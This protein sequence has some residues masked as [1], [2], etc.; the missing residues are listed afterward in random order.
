MEIFHVETGKVPKYSTESNRDE[1]LED[2]IQLKI[3]PEV[4]DLTKVD[5]SII[6]QFNNCFGGHFGR[7][8]GRG[9]KIIRAPSISSS[10][11]I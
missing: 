1:S 4:S 2:E 9:R 5:L 6:Q 3:V 8:W 7:F 10:N 11:Y